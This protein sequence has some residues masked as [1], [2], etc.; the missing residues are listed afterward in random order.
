M[1]EEL[2]EV[3]RPHMEGAPRLHLAGHSLGGSLATLVALTAHLK[4]GGSSLGAGGGSSSSHGAGGSSDSAASSLRGGGST[5]GAL[6]VKQQHGQQLREQQQEQ[7]RRQRLQVEVTTFGSP[8]VLALAHGAEEDGRS[9]LQARGE[10][11]PGSAVQHLAEA[12]MQRLTHG[13]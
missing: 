1:A 4:L 9:I 2:F 5:S 13:R 8:P 10:G 3:L 7:Q 6:P 11:G 12:C